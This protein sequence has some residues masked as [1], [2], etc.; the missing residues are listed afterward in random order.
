M[1]KPS[2]HETNKEIVSR[3]W[4]EYWGEPNPDIVDELAA[5]DIR[6][7]YPL[8]GEVQGREEVKKRIIGY[9]QRFPEGRFEL[10]DELIAEGDRVV[11]LWEGGGTHTG[12]S[13]ELP[14]GSL[15]EASGEKAQY[16][17]TTVFTVRDGQIIEEYG[18][19][20]YFGVMQQLGLIEPQTD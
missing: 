14:L 12:R 13:W 3:W 20:D 15:P 4:S 5:D 16:T 8:A 10:T 9:K 1:A 18:Q 7:Y 11:A 2:T 6:W 17:G 19:A